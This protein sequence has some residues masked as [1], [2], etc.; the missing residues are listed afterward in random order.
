MWWIHGPPESTLLWVWTVSVFQ[1]PSGCNILCLFLWR[2]WNLDFLQ[3]KRTEG[4]DF[5]VKSKEERALPVS[6]ARVVALSLAK[7]KQKEFLIW[8][9]LSN[10]E[11]LFWTCARQ[12]PE[13]HGMLTRS[14]HFVKCALSSSS[15]AICPSPPPF[16]FLLP[17]VNH[18]PMLHMRQVGL[19]TRL[20][21]GSACVFTMAFITVHVGWKL[22]LICAW[23]SCY[24][25][26]IKLAV[27]SCQPLCRRRPPPPPPRC[28]LG[29]SSPRLVLGNLPPTY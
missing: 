18:F 21:R 7:G 4:R 1:C 9:S 10:K 2:L 28:V 16:F 25:S 3:L 22:L 5:V 11:F 29:Q 13:K 19:K 6:Y 17:T 27:L 12:L 15:K 23:W 8:I 26:T 24:T 20:K 14:P